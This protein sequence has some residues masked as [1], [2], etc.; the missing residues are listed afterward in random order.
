VHGGG[1][2]PAGFAEV[3]D[4]GRDLAGKTAET[5]FADEGA[6]GFFFENPKTE[7]EHG[8]KTSVAQEFVPGFLFGERAAAEE[9]RDTG[10]GQHGAASR[11]IVEAVATQAEARAFK[12]RDFA[13][14]KGFEHRE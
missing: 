9:A 5:S 1:E 3:F 7:A 8:P 4:R 2:D 6:S 10:I 12:H 11:E 13:V 14:G